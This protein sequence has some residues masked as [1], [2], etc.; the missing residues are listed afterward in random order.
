M[1]NTDDEAGQDAPTDLKDQ[2]SKDEIKNPKKKTQGQLIQEALGLEP[3]DVEKIEKKLFIARFLD[4]I[5]EESFDFIFKD[6][7]LNK[8]KQEISTFL[9][10]LEEEEDKLLKRRLEDK[11]I[12]EILDKVKKEGE[13]I[14]EKEGITKPVDK[15]LKK[16]SVI[17]SLVMF[18][19]VITLVFLPVDLFI[20][21]PV[22]CLFCVIPQLLRGYM[23]KK[24]VEFKEEHKNEL[25]KENREDIMIIKGYVAE[26]L[27]N[28]RAGLLEIDRKSVV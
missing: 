2:E 1:N 19:A 27:E 25:Y 11:E 9:E 3:R 24:W 10:S 5:S 18:G 12:F 14:A 16:I 28:I 7:S 21:L 8:Y 15:R 6:E 17:I 23:L 26:V 13:K 22:L 20:V 4:Y